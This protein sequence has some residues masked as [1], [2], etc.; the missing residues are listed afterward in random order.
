METY[1]SKVQNSK[2]KSFLK[3][4]ENRQQQTDSKVDMESKRLRIANTI[5]KKMIDERKIW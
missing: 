2:E 4:A 3:Y 5:W 1:H